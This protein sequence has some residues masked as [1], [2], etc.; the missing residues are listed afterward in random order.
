MK[1]KI[2]FLLTGFLSLTFFASLQTVPA[3]AG[4]LDKINAASQKLQQAADQ[5]NQKA[6]QMEAGQN[7]GGAKK[8]FEKTKTTNPITGDWGT[9][10]TCA[11]PN[12]AT[13]AN[14]MDNLVN[15]MHQ[16]QGYYYRLVAANLEEKL[17]TGENLSAQERKD[18]EA[19]IASVKD[20]INTGKV[21]DPDP[22]NPQ[23][24]L[25]RLSDADQQEI[26]GTNNKYMR[27]VHDDCDARFGGMSQ[28]SN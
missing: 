28:Y 11:G 14:G 2:Q 3:T 9:Q 19:D 17:Q 24:W 27:E 13:C 4:F 15:C 25:T 20:A 6:A 5:M 8:T 10:V 23:C 26:N 7:M 18:L 21:V 16:T 12:T 1:H 22:K